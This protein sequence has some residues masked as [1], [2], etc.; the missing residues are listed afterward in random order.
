MRVNSKRLARA[1]VRTVSGVQ[2]GKLA[3][4]DLD[5]ES[6]KLIAIR[7]APRGVVSGL[8]SEELV[9]AWQYVVSMDEEEIIVEDA[10]VHSSAKQFVSNLNASFKSIPSGTHLE[11]ISKIHSGA[12]TSNF[13]CNDLQDSSKYH[14]VFLLILQAFRSK[15][16]HFC[17]KSD[18]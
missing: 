10:S 9:I 12:K 18:F 6:G 1:M 14:S 7:V 11:P 5:G 16:I 13:G 2:V 8:L 15:L 17:L 4:I 3:S